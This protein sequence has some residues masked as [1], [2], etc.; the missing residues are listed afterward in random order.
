MAEEMVGPA[1]ITPR[2]GVRQRGLQG[3]FWLAGKAVA[4]TRRKEM[5][6]ELSL[7]LPV[8]CPQAE[9]A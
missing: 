4:T 1:H 3:H 7:L 9:A 6:P 8:P 5:G 2:L